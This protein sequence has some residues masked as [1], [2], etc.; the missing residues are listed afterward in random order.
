MLQ[1]Y[2]YHQYIWKA[3]AAHSQGDE[4]GQNGSLLTS[5]FLSRRLL[6][7]KTLLL[8]IG[9]VWHNK[10]QNQ[11]LGAKNKMLSF[12]YVISQAIPTC[13]CNITELGPHAH[14]FQH[15]YMS[16]GKTTQ[17]FSCF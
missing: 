9:P 12:L 5:K 16:S 8:A 11:K 14:P 13:Q 6:K 15:R 4:K 10:S 1:L 7:K 17:H 2:I 3:Q